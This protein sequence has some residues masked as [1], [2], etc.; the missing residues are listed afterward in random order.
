[1]KKNIIFAVVII[2][3]AAIISLFL[4]LN[5]QTGTEVLVSVA[6]GKS[7]TL[8][9]ENDSI[10]HIGADYGAKL[11]VTLEIKDGA[12]RFIDSVCQDHICEGFGW[13]SHAGD[14]AVCM[15]AGV[16]ISVKQ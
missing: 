13:V 2:V 5:P 8:S 6:D 15:P 14:T 3:I 7:T 1:M 12:V 10:V 4:Y 11:D 16:M 9:L